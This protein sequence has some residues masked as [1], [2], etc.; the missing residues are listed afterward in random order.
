MTPRRDS[1]IATPV[2]L[3]TARPI[4]VQPQTLAWLTRYELRWDL[5]VMRDWGDYMAA[6]GF[7]RLTVHELRGY[8]FAA[9]N[10]E[11]YLIPARAYRDNLSY[12]I[13]AID[14]RSG[15]VLWQ[16]RRDLPD[17]LS[18]A[19]EHGPVVRARDARPLR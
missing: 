15:V 10:G 7:K 18:L 13:E 9:P 2:V 11:R 1:R 4:R 17:D 8:G 14:A 19:Q 16:Y 6:P 3:L 5:L 12:V